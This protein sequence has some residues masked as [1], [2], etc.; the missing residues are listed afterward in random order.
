MIKRNALNNLNS[1]S[2]QRFGH[3]DKLAALYYI[4]FLHLQIFKFTNIN[5]SI[6]LY[7]PYV[8]RMAPLAFIY[9]FFFFREK[10]YT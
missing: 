1:E 4:T 3:C 2:M 6:V 8:L 9:L 7:Y 10:E 5:A